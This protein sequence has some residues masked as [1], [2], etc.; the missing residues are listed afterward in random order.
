MLFFQILDYPEKNLQGTNS[1]AYF[2]PLSVTKKKKYKNYV[3]AFKLYTAVMNTV[4]K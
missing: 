2:D 3:R 1:L 4:V